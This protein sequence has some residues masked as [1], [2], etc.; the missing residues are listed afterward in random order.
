MNV[1][2]RNILITV[3][4]SSI[5]MENSYLLNNIKNTSTEVLKQRVRDRGNYLIKRLKALT[6]FG[7]NQE[8]N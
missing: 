3:T 1:C 4:T 5:S 2:S 6:P 8:L 7:L